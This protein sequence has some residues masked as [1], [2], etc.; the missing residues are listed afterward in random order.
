ML[1]SLGPVPAAYA[2]CIYFFG[3]Q[4]RG[5]AHSV[6]I[7]LVLWCVLQVFLGLVVG[8]FHSLCL[9]SVVL[10]ECTMLVMGAIFLY[11]VKKKMEAGDDTPPP[12]TPTPG[13]DEVILVFVPFVLI[14]ITFMKGIAEPIVN[15]DSLAYHLPTMVQWHQTGYLSVWRDALFSRYPFNWE[16]ICVLYYYPFSNDMM[17]TFPNYMAI[18]MLYVSVY[19]ISVAHG[20]TSKSA[21]MGTA[22]LLA[23]PEVVNSLHTM[24]ID[25][26]FAALFMS[27]LFLIVYYVKTR[28][29]AYLFLFF[30]S[31]GLFLGIKTSSFAYGALL[32][33]VLLFLIFHRGTGTAIKRVELSAKGKVMLAVFMLV[34]LFIG[35]FWYVKNLIEVGNPLGYLKVKLLGH[36]IFDGT[37]DLAKIPD[38]TLLSKFKIFNILHWKVLFGE[39]TK[40]LGM[41][42]Y[43]MMATVIAGLPLYGIKKK[44]FHTVNNSMFIFLIMS[45]VVICIYWVMPFGADA[46]STFTTITPWIGQGFRYVIT[47][48]SLLAVAVSLVLNIIPENTAFG[49]VILV[50]GSS[51]IQIAEA[52]YGREYSILYFIFFFTLFM[53]YVITSNFID[54]VT[55]QLF[56]VKTSVGIIIM[57]I[58]LVCIHI[59]GGTRQQARDAN[60][61]YSNTSRYIDANLK[62]GEK[63]GYMYLNR[64]YPLTGYRWDIAIEYIKPS[65]IKSVEDI[66]VQMK[67]RN[68]R[69]LA[70]GME[71]WDAMTP[72]VLDWLNDTDGLFQKVS[73]NNPK[74]EIVLYALKEASDIKL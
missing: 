45:L 56:L 32:L 63:L 74:F 61:M 30:L 40:R 46:G 54:A 64:P 33:A 73:G 13:N 9:I 16:L 7:T 14:L 41:P 43:I 31:F 60:F 55:R 38:T 17:V 22:L 5:A 6:L 51:V 48:F 53:L 34:S 11:C 35:G 49:F 68:I 62:K 52:N 25:M 37:F 57:L 70:V 59:A 36:Q 44:L 10:G 28:E 67:S 69:Y 18:V 27:S 21:L 42:F 66:A 12:T 72:V 47:L 15:Y 19:G 65:G 23:I 8:I 20:A 1:I 4:G 58:F 3:S 26:P 50:T 29:I 2:V 39:M 71:F 24:H